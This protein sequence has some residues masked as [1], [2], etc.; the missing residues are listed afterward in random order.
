MEI[1]YIQ[2]SQIDDKKWDAC[3]SQSVNGAVFAYSWYLDLVAEQW[4]ALVGDD[5]RAV[6]PLVYRR[7]LGSLSLYNP[8]FTRYLGLFG[9]LEMNSRL[10]QSFIDS[11]PGKIKRGSLIIN[12]FNTLPATYKSVE[13][14]H[15]YNIDLMESRMQLAANLPGETR[16]NINRA[17]ALGLFVQKSLSMAQLAEF[18]GSHSREISTEFNMNVLKRIMVQSTSLGMCVT[19]GC[20]TSKNELCAVGVFL[21]SQGK[22]HCLLCAQSHVGKEHS[23]LSLLIDSVMAEYAQRPMVLEFDGSDK[24]NLPE[25]LAFLPAKVEFPHLKLKGL[26]IWGRI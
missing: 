5:Y 22:I 10:L 15:T 18:V 4:D 3:I 9:L 25:I 14:R 11:I 17:T 8:L 1:K 16:N 24:L 7:N 2:R 20:F 6:F 12:P 13:S 19:Y 21:K 26:N 23:A